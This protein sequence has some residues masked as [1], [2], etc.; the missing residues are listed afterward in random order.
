[1]L[2][3]SREFHDRILN[4]IKEGE[5]K[6]TYSSRESQQSQNQSSGPSPSTASSPKLAANTKPTTSSVANTG[7]RSQR[8]TK[9][10][11]ENNPQEDEL[12]KV[13]GSS[14]KLKKIFHNNFSR[15]EKGTKTYIHRLN[16][17]NSP[18]A[19]PPTKKRRQ[20]TFTVG[21]TSTSAESSERCD[22]REKDTHSHRSE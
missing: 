18:P 8:N 1:M 10:F 9:K 14:T 16:T 5:R 20:Q 21:R 19:S 13:L 17:K 4:N 3:R 6:R 2:F 12:Q 22:N 11:I 15:S 7:A